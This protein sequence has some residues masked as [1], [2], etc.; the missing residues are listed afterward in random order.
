MSYEFILFF[1][2]KYMQK[3][4][5]CRFHLSLQAISTFHLKAQDHLFQMT[6][7]INPSWVRDTKTETRQLSADLKRSANQTEV[8]MFV[9]GKIQLIQVQSPG[10]GHPRSD[11]FP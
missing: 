10:A 2:F 9:A 11:Y 4:K 5:A 1:L 7:I 3:K 6:V 8:E